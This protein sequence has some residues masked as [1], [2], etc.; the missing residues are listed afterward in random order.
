MGRVK[1]VLD[2]SVAVAALRKTEPFHV[3]SLRHCMP[4]FRGKDQ[5]LVPAT[6]EIEVV[7]ALVRRGAAPA[8]VAVLFERS[9][10]ARRAVT[11]GPRAALAVR[12]IVGRTRLPAAAA[13]YAWLAAR[14]N[15]PLVT[16]DRELLDRASLAGARAIT[17]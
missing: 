14:D 17:P 8:R 2:A 7:S 9:F 3:E 10:A 6:F 11:I 4:L 15:L 12:A 1:Y 16:I 5:I 13:L